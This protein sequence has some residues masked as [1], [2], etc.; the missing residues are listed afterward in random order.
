[1]AKKEAHLKH[2]LLKLDPTKK[3][4]QEVIKLLEHLRD[5]G[6]S[7]KTAIIEA[8][9]SLPQEA[10]QQRQTPLSAPL[11]S[12]EV[13]LEQVQEIKHLLLRYALPR[14]DKPSEPRLETIS[15]VTSGVTAD[16]IDQLGL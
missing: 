10:N 15:V 5:E 8:L 6:I 7:H 4:E 11:T 2:I 3:R 16:E 9:L 12:H 14:A 13:L 1:M